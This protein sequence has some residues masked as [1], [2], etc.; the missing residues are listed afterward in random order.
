MPVYSFKTMQ[1]VPSAEDFVD[2]ILTRTQ[3]RTPT[4]IHAGYKIQRI[5][6][7]Y[8]RK[9]KF[10]QQNF[11]E[12][13]S[14]IIQ[15]FPK[16]DDIHPFYADL[17]NI[18][19]DRDHYK[20]ALGQINMCRGLIDHLA[21]DYTKLLKYSDSLYRCKQLK[22]AALGRMCT[23]MRKQ[24]AGLS[25]LEEVRKHLA[26]LPT[27]DPNTRTLLVTGF[28]NVGKSSFMNKVSRANV[29][30]QSY[31]FTT[32]SLFVGHMD[33]KYL[34][35]QVIDSPG[36]LDHP[37]ED[38]NTIEM[39]AITA[40]AHLQCAILY[41]IDISEECGFTVAQQMSL[42]TNIRPLFVNK[43]LIMVVNKIDVQPWET[44]E[45]DKKAL[46]EAGLKETNAHMIQMS[47][48]TE[49][50]IMDVKAYACDTLLKQRIETKVSG[51]KV[52]TVIN[53][54]NVAQP[55][56]R[57]DKKRQT[58]IPASVLAARQGRMETDDAE[59]V[60][61]LANG[62]RTQ[63]RLNHIKNPSGRKLQKDIMNENGGAGVYAMDYTDH[64]MLAK[65]E[66]KTDFVPEIMDGKNVADFID[67]DIAEKLE[68]L[69][70]EEEARLAEQDDSSESD[71]DETERDLVKTIRKKKTLIINAHRANRQSNRSRVPRN[72]G[73]Q[74]KGKMVAHLDSLNVES[75]K[76]EKR[77]RK[78]TR[79]LSRGVDREAD[80]EDDEREEAQAK[81]QKA[82]SH[83]KVRTPQE[84]GYASESMESKVMSLKQRS[85]QVKNKGGQ[86]IQGRAG[87][88]DRHYVDKMPKW[89]NSGKTSGQKT[90]DYR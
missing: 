9:V 17:L 57:D 12:K 83:S 88:S 6:A 21:K 56:L 4:V 27:I 8:M 81:R 16:M 48:V 36:I 24:K 84:K 59:D 71:V 37:L 40:L 85:Q 76:A 26:R 1:P 70:R 2:I 90:R 54:L 58:S 89:L 7:F 45:A 15:D 62:E 20:L 22:R 42:F 39:Q 69:E 47:N 5:R 29:D 77:G 44:L 68:A 72:K 82:R 30:V 64:Y 65:D 55:S 25:Y 87:E 61:G 75:S 18:L 38:R 53:R 51:N 28:P 11:N 78:R 46:I 43:P 52:G 49:V 14:Q 13:L 41:F 3:R 63:S 50:G 32:K 60:D 67:P 80:M 19:Y 73:G 35:W 33:Y 34:R 10:T 23:L 31:A 79:S 66:W 74:D 86:N